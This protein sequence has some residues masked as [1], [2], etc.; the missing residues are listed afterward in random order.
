M[1]IIEIAVDLLDFKLCL[2]L[3]IVFF[4]GNKIGDLISSFIS[5]YLNSKQES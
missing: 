4:L 2:N 5:K 3:G 1:N